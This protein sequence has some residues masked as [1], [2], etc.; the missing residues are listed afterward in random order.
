MTEWPVISGGLIATGLSLLGAWRKLR[1][2]TPTIP[3]WRKVFR[4]ASATGRLPLAEDALDF[5]TDYNKTL[6]MQRDSMRSEL[7]QAMSV[8]ASKD[9]EIASLRSQLRGSSTD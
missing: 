1:N 5:T 7:A 8:I 6:L 2:G 9:S 4:W 3:I